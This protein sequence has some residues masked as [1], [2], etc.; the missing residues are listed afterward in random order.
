MSKILIFTVLDKKAEAFM[1]PFF[2]RAKG[3]AIRSFSD[4]I[5]TKDTMLNKYP[6]DYELFY[7][8]EYDEITAGIKAL[9][10]ESLGIGIDYTASKE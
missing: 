5:N 4:E 10:P 1:R 7:L 2:A 9:S 3:E 6:A 8:G